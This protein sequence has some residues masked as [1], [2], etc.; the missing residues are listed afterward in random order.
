MLTLIR[1]T[2]SSSLTENL[3]LRYALH[4]THLK[5]R[6]LGHGLELP[7]L[8]SRHERGGGDFRMLP[9]SNF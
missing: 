9:T 2:G 8:G 7:R 3:S 5:G 6:N 4:I 1:G